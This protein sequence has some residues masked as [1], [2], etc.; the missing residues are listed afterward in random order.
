MEIHRNYKYRLNPNREEKDFLENH[1]F[2][3]NQ[4]WNYALAF[5]IN[6]LKEMKLLPK[7][8]R[9]YTKFKDLYSL[10]INHLRERNITFN[11]G[12]IQDELRK[13]D[14]TFKKYYTKKSDGQGFP[15]FKSSSEANQSIVIRNQSSSWT[16]DRLKIFRKS[17]KT[18]FHREIPK[19]A[20]YNGGV[21]KR[22][23]DRHYYVTLNLTMDINLPEQTNKVECGI[24]MNINNI[25]I[26]DSIGQSE[27]I[28]LEDFS[29]SKYSKTFNSVKQKLSKRYKKKNF[30]KK[31]KKLQIKLNKIQKK[32][33]NKKEDRFHKISN[34]LTNKYGRI[35]IE[36]L[37]ISDMKESQSKRLNRLISDVSWN[38][39]ITKIKYK[40]AMKNVIVREINPAFSSQR[41]NQCGHISRN[42]RQSQ[43]DFHCE[44]CHH[45]ENADMN[46]SRNILQYDQW[47]LE[48]MTRLNLIKSSQ[49][50]MEC[51][52]ILL[53]GETHQL[54]APLLAAE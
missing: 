54:E 52:S 42:N 6:E 16:K 5:K 12:V 46:A 29:K 50:S 51:N 25:S 36:D 49:V 8:A 53:G 39:L 37:N 20:K 26:S 11:T 3:S 43:S 45:T 17:I 33:K 41:C 21:I 10:T 14:S 32:I 31:T 22:E 18:K 19:D 47:S 24:D 38:S 9:T 34:D 1:F 40:A 7:E 27:L 2:S 13:L 48:Q 4:A 28:K 35:T 44:N 15:K 30:S 23:S